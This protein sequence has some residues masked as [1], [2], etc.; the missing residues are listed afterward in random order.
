MSRL[1]DYSDL[2]L[3]AGISEE[4]YF[5]RSMMIREKVMPQIKISCSEDAA[6]FAREQ[7]GDYDR[8][9]MLVMA[10]NNRHGLNATSIVHI[11]S[12][13]ESI[14]DTADIIRVALN[15]CS[16]ALIVVHNHPSG[17]SAPSR[18]DRAVTKK[19]KDACALMNIRFL[20]HIIIGDGEYYSFADQ[21][22]LFS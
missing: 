6:K 1:D 21:G 4:H 12:A 9:A 3:F 20:D 17:E 13:T 22:L 15:S 16:R 8:E 14:A 5:V 7:I 2:P 19:I 18:E 10:L 11:G